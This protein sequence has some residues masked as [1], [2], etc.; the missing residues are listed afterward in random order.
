MNQNAATH[1][2]GHAKQPGPAGEEAQVVDSSALFAGDTRLW[3]RHRGELYRLQLTR[4]DRL[5][6]VK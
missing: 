4:N 3:I 1:Q 6:L 5:I 2:H